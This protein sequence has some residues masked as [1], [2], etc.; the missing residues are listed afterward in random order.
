MIRH[1]KSLG[2]QK[3]KIP[4]NG[5][6]PLMIK[7]IT[8]PIT[9]SQLAAEAQKTFG[10]MVK[11]VVDVDQ[12]MLAI[13]GELH[14]DEEAVLIEQGSK[15]DHLWGINLYPELYGQVDWLEFDSMINLRPSRGN[16]SRSVDDPKIQK[17][18]VEIVNKLVIEK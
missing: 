17:R 1:L 4:L 9:L 6:L 14:A 13:N 16:A 7:I 2:K 3:V 12:A 5:I 18:I 10:D 15:Q 11:A 8:K